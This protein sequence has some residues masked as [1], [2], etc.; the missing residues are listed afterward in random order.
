MLRVLVVMIALGVVGVGVWVRFI[1]QDINTRGFTILGVASLESQAEESTWRSFMQIAIDN[2]LRIW[3]AIAAGSFSAF[4]SIL[5]ILSLAIQ[6]LRLPTPFLLPFEL[7][8][9]LSLAT[10]FA[11]TLS[12]ALKFPATL[13]NSHSSA[14][15]ASFAMLLP[16][17]RGYAIGAGTGMF[18]SLTTT[19]S[20]F[21]QTIHR[22]RDS[23][24]CSFE[25]TASGLGMSHEYQ[26]PAMDVTQS[27][28]EEKGLVGA[29]AEMGRR[30]SVQSGKV[31]EG[32]VVSWPLA[33]AKKM[34]AANIRP[35][36][37]WSE[38]PKK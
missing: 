8:S 9:S 20:F 19:I 35:H 4:A 7:F 34:E 27:R 6:R 13:S 11:A 31:K 32:K 28:D 26:M 12:L 36:R 10:A 3:I 30:E 17:S 15:L 16:L 24:A 33:V 2:N 22:V 21:I 23:K 29:G 37:P 14:D 5:I 38:M 18:L 1:I 25:P